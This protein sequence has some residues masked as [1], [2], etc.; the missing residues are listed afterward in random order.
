MMSCNTACGRSSFV[1]TPAVAD[2]K[3]GIIARSAKPDR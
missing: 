2:K 1:T 3:I